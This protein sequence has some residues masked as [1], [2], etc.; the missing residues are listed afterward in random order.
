MIRLVALLILILVVHPLQGQDARWT[1]T[2][3]L[4]FPVI[5]PSET[6]FPDVRD[7]VVGPGGQLFLGLYHLRSIRAFDADGR[8]LTAF[9]SPG[10]GPGQITDLRHL[11]RLGDTIVAIDARRAV[12]FG[13]DGT[14]RGDLW[15]T[16]SL[17]DPDPRFARR[18][19]GSSPRSAG[20]SPCPP[21]LL[22]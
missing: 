18:P 12:F 10:S 17:N 7:L 1:L 11:G 13:A 14:P 20:G 21:R 5:D 15:A 22:R 3:E 19:K 2:E 8:F 9:G 6:A 16:R 4:R